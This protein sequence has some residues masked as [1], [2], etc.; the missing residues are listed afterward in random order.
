MAS[1]A[2]QP[3]DTEDRADRTAL[4][5]LT[6]S[7]GRNSSETHVSHGPAS[8]HP[9]H[10]NTG[11]CCHFHLQHLATGQTE[12]NADRNARC[13]LNDSRNL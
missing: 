12:T 2:A 1:T 13:R 8:A 7:L 11:T 5:I 3:E 10:R 4:G 9:G 6:E